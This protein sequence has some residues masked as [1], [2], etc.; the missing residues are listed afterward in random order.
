MVIEHR[1]TLEKIKADHLRVRYTDPLSKMAREVGILKVQDDDKHKV[2]AALPRI[3][4]HYYGA[5][6]HSREFDM[7]REATRGF[8]INS[9]IQQRPGIRVYKEGFTTGKTFGILTNIHFSMKVKQEV[10]DNPDEKLKIKD[11]GIPLEKLWWHDMHKWAGI[12]N[13]IAECTPFAAPGDSGALVC[14]VEESQT[15][16]LGIHIGRLTFQEDCSILLGLEACPGATANNNSLEKLINGFYGVPLPPR[17][18]PAPTKRISDIAWRG[19]GVDP[20]SS[21][22][23]WSTE[24]PDQMQ[25]KKICRRRADLEYLRHGHPDYLDLAVVIGPK[26]NGKDWLERRGGN[27]AGSVHHAWQ[28]SR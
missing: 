12:V 22:D 4:L 23:G 19:D 7:E 10:R 27:E 13:W 11:L 24:A 1:L 6:G 3:S 18:P 8:Q 16:P 20:V 26:S 28:A 14:A 15:V 5:N 21:E 2:E 9:L 25:S 17:P